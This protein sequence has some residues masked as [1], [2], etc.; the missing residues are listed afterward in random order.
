MSA[1]TPATRSRLARILGRLRGH[2][3]RFAALAVLALVIVVAAAAWTF[4]GGSET[5]LTATV[6]RGTLVARLTETGIL[7]AAQSATYRSPIGGR[8]EELV[9]LA[10]EGMRV[11]AGDLVARIDTTTV[12]AEIQRALQAVRQA[13]VELQVTLVDRQEALA[14]VQSLTDGMKAIEVDEAKANLSLAE[15]KLARLK[16]EYE[17]LK[18]LLDRGFVTREELEKSALEL[19]QAS[20]EIDIARRKAGL[21][22]DRTRPQEA[23]RAALQLS[24][25]EAQLGQSRQKLEE[26]RQQLQALQSARN[27]CAIYAKSPGLVLYEDYLQTY[28]RRKIRVGDRVTPS[29]GIVTIPEV[30]RMLVESSVR[31]ADMHRVNVGQRAAV[32]VDAYPDV[33]LS[34]TVRSIGTL[35]RASAERPNEEKRFDLVVDLDA[36]GA[37]LRPEMTARL[38]IVTGERRDVLLLPSNAV[39]DRD[40]GPVAYVVGTWSIDAR[41]IVLGEASE[42]EVEVTSGLREG[43]RVSLTDRRRAP[44]APAPKMAPSSEGRTEVR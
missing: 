38:E 10:P 9:F 40:G 44:A 2:P 25:R 41:Q 3:V 36:T 19:E 16:Q 17:S 13:E 31:E 26:A 1:D 24:Q 43:E 5:A 37:D 7:R 21:L 18:P 34:G 27:G 14:A 42:F 29:Q 32:R 35:A 28:P 20:A 11:N 33:R 6:R 39:F 4:R 22:V 23:E 15:K 30:H 12:D 8:E